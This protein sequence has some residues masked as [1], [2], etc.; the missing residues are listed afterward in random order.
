ME[1]IVPDFKNLNSHPP[2]TK[3][4]VAQPRANRAKTRTV[5]RMQQRLTTHSY[6]LTPDLKKLEVPIMMVPTRK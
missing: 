6:L 2:G 1:N 5:K 3:A 4:S